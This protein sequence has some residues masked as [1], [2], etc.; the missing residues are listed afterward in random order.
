MALSK[1][2]NFNFLKQDNHIENYNL[3]HGNKKVNNTV[4]KS[5]GVQLSI[6]HSDNASQDRNRKPEE[7]YDQSG[8]PLGKGSTMFM[9][10]NGKNNNVNGSDRDAMS[11]SPSKRS[12]I[13]HLTDD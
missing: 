6:K 10:K 8:K 7:R 4:F 11:N 5:S 3:I 2:R 13:I 9:L 12:G 1:S